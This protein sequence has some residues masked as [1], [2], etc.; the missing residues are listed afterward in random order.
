MTNLDTVRHDKLPQPKADLEKSAVGLLMDDGDFVEDRLIKKTMCGPRTH[1]L[2]SYYS[3]DDELAKGTLQIPSKDPKSST[4]QIRLEIVEQHKVPVGDDRRDFKVHEL[5]PN[6][7]YPR[8][9]HN[10]KGGTGMPAPNSYNSTC[11]HAC[12]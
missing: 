1:R 10:R 11:W 8:S 9:P 12:I 6:I 7:I 2:V 3:A 4:L 5:S